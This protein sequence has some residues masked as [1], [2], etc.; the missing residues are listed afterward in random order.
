MATTLMVQV[1]V[2][3][4][5]LKAIEIDRSRNLFAKFTNEEFLAARLMDII[6]SYVDQH[7]T[8]P[9]IAVIVNDLRVKPDDLKTEAKKRGLDI[10]AAATVDAVD[11]SVDR[12]VKG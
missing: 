4:L 1:D 10:D 8:Q 6:N 5:Q 2:D 3:D 9:Q 12:I 7:I 11:V